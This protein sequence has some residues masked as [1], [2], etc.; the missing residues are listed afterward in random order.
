M[1]TY[2]KYWFLEGF[3]LFNKLGRI[4]MM[5]MCEILEME[6]INKGETIQLL[7]NNEKSI[8]FLKKGTIKIIDALNNNV[9]YIV[10]KGN[11]FGELSL[12]DKQAALEEQAVAL[13]DCIICYIEA[14]RMENI[15]EKHK[16]LKNGVLKVYGLRIKK[17]ERRLRDLLYKDSAL[18]IEEFIK[19]YIQE[20]GEIE[21]NQIVAKNLL[22]HKDIANLTNTSRQTVSNVMSCLRKDDIISY[23]SQY[24]SIPKKLL[25]T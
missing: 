7:K 10:K 16:S 8:F 5:R 6:N 19:D 11:I 13:E 9:K 2:T 3:N 21:E 15:M 24:I 20:F 12:Y 18:R 22:S 23:N 25:P 14:D 1:N 4:T 17:L